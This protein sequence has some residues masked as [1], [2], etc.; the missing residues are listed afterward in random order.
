MNFLYRYTELTINDNLS[1]VNNKKYRY[2]GT[3]EMC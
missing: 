3:Y 1:I 2:S